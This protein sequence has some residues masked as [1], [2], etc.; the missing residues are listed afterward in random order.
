MQS[1]PTARR[2][3]DA[4]FPMNPYTILRRCLFAL[5]IC[6]ACAAS[7]AEKIVAARGVDFSNVQKML[8]EGW[9]VKAQSS[10]VLDT[11]G[12]GSHSPDGVLHVFTLTPP[13]PERQAEN[14]VRRK[15]EFERRREEYLRNKRV[16]R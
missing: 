16:E 15:E 1:A 11:H 8:D 2:T 10:V 5:A 3:S 4:N 12:N 6:S 9:Q 13:S 7:D 14:E